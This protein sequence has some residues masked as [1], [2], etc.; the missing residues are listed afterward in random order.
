MPLNSIGCKPTL[1]SYHKQSKKT[2]QNSKVDNKFTNKAL[3]NLY[4]AAGKI[5]L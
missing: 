1:K 5:L 2:G 4:L 3:F